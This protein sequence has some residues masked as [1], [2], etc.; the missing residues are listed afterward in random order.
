MTFT[1]HY[2]DL[3]T[4]ATLVDQ[5]DGATT[6]EQAEIITQVKSLIDSNHLI[7]GLILPHLVIMH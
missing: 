3:G 5:Y 4:L 1:S 6:A 2:G 7:W